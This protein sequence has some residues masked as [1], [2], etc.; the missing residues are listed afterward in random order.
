MTANLHVFSI[1]SMLFLVSGAV[2]GLFSLFA[3]QVVTHTC[4]TAIQ[5]K[6]L[7][8]RSWEGGMLVAFM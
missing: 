5:T 3:L 2:G 7:A 4:R 1:F 8:L 6:S